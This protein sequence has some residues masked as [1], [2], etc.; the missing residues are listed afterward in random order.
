M[1]LDG[2]GDVVGGAVGD[3]LG[4]A[5]DRGERGAQ[6]VGDRQQELALEAL[7]PTEVRAQGVDGVGQLV[8]LGG[9]AAVAP[10]PWRRDC[11][12]RDLAGG[13]HGPHDRAR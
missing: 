8:E 12:P 1:M 7:G 6:L 5:A 13:V 4:V 3:G 9:L 2:A 10:G 11:R